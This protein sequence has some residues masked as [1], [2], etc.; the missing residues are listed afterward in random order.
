MWAIVCVCVCRRG[1]LLVCT[2]VE[3]HRVCSA[4]LRG[5]IWSIRGLRDHSSLPRLATAVSEK[6]ERVSTCIRTTSSA[7]MAACSLLLHSHQSEPLSHYFIIPSTWEHLR[8]IRIDFLLCFPEHLPL[9]PY[10]TKGVTQRGLRSWR[11]GCCCHCCCCRCCCWCCCWGC[12]LDHSVGPLH[13]WMSHAKTGMTSK[14]RR[15]ETQTSWSP[16]T[17]E[18][19]VM[20]MVPIL[21]PATMGPNS[22]VLGTTPHQ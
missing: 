15:G 5:W 2:G 22:T 10:R 20:V 7:G 17:Q 3:L 19:E 1:V 6:I 11:S 8:A 21:Q 18:T 13:H 12:I 4:A 14:E 16:E 9:F